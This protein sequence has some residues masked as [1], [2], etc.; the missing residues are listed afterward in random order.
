MDPSKHS[1]TENVPQLTRIAY[2]KIIIELNPDYPVP[3]KLGDGT[4]QKTKTVAYLM[5]AVPQLKQVGYNQNLRQVLAVFLA[6]EPTA[7]KPDG[8]T[9]DWL[10][11]RSKATGFIDSTDGMRDVESE[12][13]DGEADEEDEKEGELGKHITGKKGDGGGAP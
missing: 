9:P 2:E 12:E 11:E 4:R 6:S 13:K 10:P 7:T 5:N 8:P 1:P 3:F